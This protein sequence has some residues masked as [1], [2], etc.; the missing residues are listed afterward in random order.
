M[1]RFSRCPKC[2]KKGFYVSVYDTPTENGELSTCRYCSHSVRTVRK[3]AGEEYRGYTLTVSPPRKGPT[4]EDRYDGNAIKGS[5]K[6]SRLVTIARLSPEEAILHLKRNIDYWE[7]IEGL[8]GKTNQELANYLVDDIL[9]DLKISL[10]DSQARF[11]L[12]VADRLRGIGE[13]EY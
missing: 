9:S 7:G 6:I 4:G 11:L 1:S 3:S 2:H 8:E 10:N 5:D 12:E 13:L